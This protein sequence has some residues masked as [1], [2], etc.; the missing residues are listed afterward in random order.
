MRHRHQASADRSETVAA[1]QV[2][3]QCPQQGQHLHAIALDVVVSVLAELRIAGPVPL[4]FDCPSLP[5]QS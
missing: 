4:V 2:E 3:G 5:N 1:Q